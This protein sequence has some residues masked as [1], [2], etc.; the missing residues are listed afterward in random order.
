MK[1]AFIASDLSLPG[2]GMQLA[3]LALA[4]K[5]DGH[6]IS[7]TSLGEAGAPGAWLAERGVKV[8]TFPSSSW[9]LAPGLARFSLSTLF[10]RPEVLQTWGFRADIAGKT[11]GFFFGARVVVSSLR[12]TETP[13]RMEA[14]RVT[15][16]LSAKTVANSAWLASL[17]GK[18]GISKSQLSVIPNSVDAASI[19]HKDRRKPAKDGKWKMLFAGH[20]S[21]GSGTPVLISALAGLSKAGMPFKAIFVGGQDAGFDAEMQL[22]MDECGISSKVDVRGPAGQEEM[23]KLMDDS[24]MLIAPQIIGWTPNTMLEAFASG[25]PVVAANIE[26]VKE[27]MSDG[28]AGRLVAPMDPTSLAKGIADAA[29]DYD[30]SVRMAREARRAALEKHSPQAVHKA[31]LDLYKSLF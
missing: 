27:L 2:Q 18:C 24:H 3:R 4:A 12:S 23:R 6:D 10:E 11:L 22:H 31:Y 19:K 29:M 13:K 17:A 14:E 26:G 25:L 8:R 30:G 28:R 20:R 5:E 16:F 9:R 15:S 7:V 1:I 21:P